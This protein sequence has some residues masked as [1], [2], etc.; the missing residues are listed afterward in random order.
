MLPA[1]ESL[2]DSAV[3]AHAFNWGEGYSTSRNLQ[4][5]SVTLRESVRAHADYEQKF[6]SRWDH[7]IR[8]RI[9]TSAS[10]IARTARSTLALKALVAF[11]V[12]TTALF[13]PLQ[14]AVPVVRLVGVVLVQ[15][16]VH[17]SLPGGFGGV[18]G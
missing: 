16:G 8:Q 2:F 7:L 3:A 18:L 14:T 5:A 10:A 15:T 6:M 11:A 12:V 1:V 9:R 13:S 17:P 4:N